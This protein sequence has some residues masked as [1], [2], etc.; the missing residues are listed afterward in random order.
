MAIQRLEGKS[1]VFVEKEGN[2][3]A[4]NVTLGLQDGEWAEVMEGLQ[5]GER[6]VAEGSFVV[7]AQIG[8]AGAEH[9]H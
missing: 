8:K 1:V 4:R 6:Y 3:E 7:K 9:V 2:Y 5:A